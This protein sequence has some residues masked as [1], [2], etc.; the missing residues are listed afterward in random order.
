M[1]EAGG[2]PAKAVAVIGLG[3]LGACIAAAFA[4]RGKQVVGVDVV[5]SVIEALASGRAPVSEPGLEEALAAAG[6]RLRA[7]SDV[8]AAVRASDITFV[9]VPTPS[10][11]SG[12]FSLDLIKPAFA[13]IGRALRSG[14]AW[15][16][17]VLTST[18]L[19]GQ[20]RTALV[21]ILERES[22]KR[23][24][25]DFGVCY[26]PA[27][28]ALGSVIRDF[29]NPDLVLVGESDPRAGDA[30]AAFY[31]EV[32]EN[33]AE[34]RRM[35]IENAELAKIGVNTFV[36]TKIAFA[37][38]LADLCERLPG[39]D[40]D[41]VTNALGLDRRIGRPYL[42]GGLGYGGP[43]FPRDNRA[44]SFLARALGTTAH[45]AE[46]TDRANDALPERVLERLKGFTERRSR[47]AV[48]G[49]AYKPATSVTEGS[50]GVALA[51]ALAAAG[52]RVS[53]YDPLANGTAHAELPSSVALVANLQEALTGAELVLLC[54]PDPAFRALERGAFDSCARPVTVL[55]FWRLLAGGLQSDPAI[56]YVAAGRTLDPARAVEH[57][58]RL[59]GGSD[60]RGPAVEPRSRVGT[61]EPPDPVQAEALA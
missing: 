55:D 3:K 18:V 23:C 17:V 14:D 37:N 45:L 35:S 16:L 1:L 41:V 26:S 58:T 22:G 19:P 52:A 36:T 10:E 6:T 50:Q 51:S 11:E 24:G 59:W 5:P 44:L 27:F 21:P 49:L 43:C 54:T 61:P 12:A 13:E 39:G 47:V 33:R 60:E 48:L 31:A 4:A 53:A 38:M 28:I 30:L 20:T 34:V 46:A 57:V 8:G 25:R 2:S 32:L 40:V 7:T 42:T 29:L 15:H 56:D 9:V